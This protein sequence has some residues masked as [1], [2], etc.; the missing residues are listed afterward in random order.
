MDDVVVTFYMN[1]GQ[2]M[3][4]LPLVYICGSDLTLWRAFGVF[5]WILLISIGFFAVIGQ[6]FRFKAL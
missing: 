3:C 2:L 5:D 1:L 6:T 4:F